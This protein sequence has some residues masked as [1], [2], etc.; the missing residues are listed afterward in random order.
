MRPVASPELPPEAQ[1]AG[2]GL[3]HLDH[4]AAADEAAYRPARPDERRGLED[5]E[6][7]SQI[8][9]HGTCRF[10]KVGK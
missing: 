4:D 1:P 8:T 3:R 2:L 9:Q 7:D 5:L 6:I 10:R